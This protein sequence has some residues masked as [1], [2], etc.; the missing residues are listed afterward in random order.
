MA[1]Q[2]WT[3]AEFDGAASQKRRAIPLRKAFLA[4]IACCNDICSSVPTLL[5]LSQRMAHKDELLGG[6]QGLCAP[7]CAWVAKVSLRARTQI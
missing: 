5:V 4:D 6:S 1:T 3:I 2:L 7:N